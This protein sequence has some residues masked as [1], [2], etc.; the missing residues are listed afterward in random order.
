MLNSNGNKKHMHFLDE[1]TC[2]NDPVSIQ[3][4]VSGVKTLKSVPVSTLKVMRHPNGT[5][6]TIL[7]PLTVTECN[8]FKAEVGPFPL[9]GLF[10]PWW[11]RIVSRKH[12]FEL[13]LKD[14]WQIVISSIPDVLIYKDTT[15]FDDSHHCVVNVSK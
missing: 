7:R 14:I 5:E 9:K 12:A 6:S 4:D 2:S 1:A 13:K 8:L 15:G 3:T 11:R 10:E